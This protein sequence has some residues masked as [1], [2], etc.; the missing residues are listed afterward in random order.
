MSRTSPVTSRARRGG[1]PRMVGEPLSRI[2]WSPEHVA[3][4][5][6]MK[7]EGAKSSQ[8]AAAVGRTADQVRSRLNRDNDRPYQTRPLAE[9]EAGLTVK[10]CRRCQEDLPLEAFAVTKMN[11]TEY[12]RPRC[13]PCEIARHADRRERGLHLVKARAAMW[14]K[15]GKSTQ[16]RPP[17]RRPSMKPSGAAGLCDPR[18][19][20]RADRSR[21]EIGWADH[22]SKATTT[23]IPSRLKFVGS[24]SRATTGIIA[25]ENEQTRAQCPNSGRWGLRC[26]RAATPGCHANRSKRRFERTAIRKAGPTCHPYRRDVGCR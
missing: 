15:P 22:L 18:R 7:A 1:V 6:K 19:A 24:V 25:R 11:K 12:R 10:R 4:A 21:R 23:T 8:I 9:K 16:K 26:A 5:K 13:R 17:L 2:P 14:R 20:R 3:L